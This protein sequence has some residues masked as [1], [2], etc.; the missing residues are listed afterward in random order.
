M[1]QQDSPIAP[2]ASNRIAKLISGAGLALRTLF[3]SPNSA[4]A[5]A[6]ATSVAFHAVLFAGAIILLPPIVHGLRQTAREQIIIP[7]TTLANDND[8]GGIPNPGMGK[9]PTRD[10]AQEEDPSVNDSTSWANRRSDQ[11]AQAL[12]GSAIPTADIV[13]QGDPNRPSSANEGGLF[14][15]LG[16]EGGQLSNFGPRGGGGG[17]GPKS[18]MFG[19]GSNVRSIVYVCDAS[20]SMIGQ[21]DDP[22][23]RELKR[24]VDNLSPVQ[25]F[26]VLIFHETLNGS[27][28]QRI[29]DNLLMANASNKA[30][31]FDFVDN[32]QFSSINNPIPA[33]QEAFREQP[34]LIFL[35][36]HG[37]FSNH[38]NTTTN[39]EVL[40]KINAYNR[41]KTVHI[42]TIL[43]LGEKSKQIRERKDFEAIMKRIAAD[44]GGLYTKYYSDD[45]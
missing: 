11:L 8:I 13:A 26:N 9:D 27:P 3:I 36:S 43:L 31:A 30:R 5:M 19:H 35:L 22:L 44:N 25:Q 40:A 7:D 12:N 24:A 16:G 42:N 17:T 38:Y 39:E 2:P 23:K 29:S 6:W 28:F 41:E 14:V 37:D 18:K 1:T 15:P 4:T 21:G 20:G 10:A 33:L 45:F 34:Q 32:L